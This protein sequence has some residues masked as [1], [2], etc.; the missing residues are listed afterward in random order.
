MSSGASSIVE[1]HIIGKI[2][3]RQYWGTYWA[4]PVQTQSC[5]RSTSRLVF[6]GNNNT[7]RGVL[8]GA[9]YGV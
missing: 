7:G 8:G 1:D 5:E 9:G 4:L 3:S 6:S 2:G